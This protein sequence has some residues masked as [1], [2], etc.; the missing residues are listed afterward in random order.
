MSSAQTLIRR[1]PQKITNGNAMMTA[2]S[3]GTPRPLKT[4]MSRSKT[5]LA[6]VLL[7]K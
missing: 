2:M 1:E 3:H 7:M 6:S 4:G 5:G